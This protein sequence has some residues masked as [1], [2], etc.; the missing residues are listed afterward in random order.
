MENGE[1]RRSDYGAGIATA[2][3]DETVRELMWLVKC[4][5][6]GIAENLPRTVDI[7]DLIGVG[8]I[9]LIHAV[10]RYDPSRGA[11]LE[12]YARYRIKGAILDELRRSDR[13]PQA[14][15]G[16][17]KRIER[18]VEVL[19]RKT[20]KYPSDDEIAMEAGIPL[21]ASIE[22]F[23]KCGI[24]LCDSC[25]IDGKHVCTDGP[26]FSGDELASFAELGKSKLSRSGRRVPIE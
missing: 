13:L 11:N 2:D 21:Q 23:M 10:E 3:R 12:T 15:R 26:A 4:V 5:A 8:A 18:A 6:R 16:K 22:R 7:E 25:A 19:E 24:G 14:T 17:L 1:N 20:G 9:G